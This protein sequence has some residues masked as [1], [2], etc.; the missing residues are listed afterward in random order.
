MTQYH[1]TLFLLKFLTDENIDLS[2]LLSRLNGYNRRTKKNETGTD[3]FYKDFEKIWKD[4]IERYSGHV[5][6]LKDYHLL[7]KLLTFGTISVLLDYNYTDSKGKTEILFHKFVSYNK[8]IKFVKIIDELNSIVILRNSLCHKESL[9]TFLDKAWRLNYQQGSNRRR[10]YLK[11]RQSAIAFIYEYAYNKKINSN[12]IVLNFN[13][14]RL[15]N[16][17][18]KNFKNIIVE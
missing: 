1:L 4:E 3:T 14:Y 15:K 2:T 7:I 8:K 16:K 10:D 5:D 11:E 13:Q 9:I 6:F 12:S 18:I 17:S